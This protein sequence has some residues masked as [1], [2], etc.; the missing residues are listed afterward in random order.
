MNIEEQQLV[1]KLL[2]SGAQQRLKIKLNRCPVEDEFRETCWRLLKYYH[3]NAHILAP[4]IYD[5]VN[6]K[7]PYLCKETL[8]TEKT[9]DFVDEKGHSIE[10]SLISGCLFETIFKNCGSE[11]FT[12]KVDFCDEVDEYLWYL[13]PQP[14]DN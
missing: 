11:I 7:Y 8:S 5:V 12:R 6:K 10:Y 9:P 13:F 14:K 3:K 2:L 4:I 1:V